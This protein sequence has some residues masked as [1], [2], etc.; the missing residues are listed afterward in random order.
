MQNLAPQKA[1]IVYKRMSQRDLAAKSLPRKGGTACHSSTTERASKKQYQKT[2]MQLV[3]DLCV[4]QPQTWLEPQ[5]QSPPST[6]DKGERHPCATLRLLNSLVPTAVSLWHC[7]SRTTAAR[8]KGL[9][10]TDYKY[11]MCKVSLVAAAHVSAD[12]GK[13]WENKI[14]STI[15]TAATVQAGQKQQRSSQQEIKTVPKTTSIAPK[16]SEGKKKR[17]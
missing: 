6:R 4:D 16:L 9:A 14:L 13:K 11:G 7:Q 5:V 15:L 10:S 3:L 12:I 1:S 8:A 2:A 17:I